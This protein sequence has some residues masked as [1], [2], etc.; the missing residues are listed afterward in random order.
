M[1]DTPSSTAKLD[2]FKSLNEI[3]E[4]QKFGD[5]GDFWRTYYNMAIEFDK[6]TI[7]RLNSN[8]DVLLI[9]AGLFSAINTAFIIP[10]LANLGPG[11]AD[12]TNFLIQLLL[13]NGT[14]PNFTK[15]DFVVSPAFTPPITAVRQ[16]AFFIASLG[17][18]LLAAAGAV[19]AKQW[20]Q[21]YQR[22]GQTG[23]IREQ[24]MERTKKFI[25]AK[26]W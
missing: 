18:S 2:E 16:N 17:C 12:Q 1:S 15:A 6:V 4:V 11:P 23:S 13:I 5:L 20:L 19:I 21:Y 3:Y 22:A 8:L 24:G 26:T 25:G 14:N 10:S 7:E 9:F